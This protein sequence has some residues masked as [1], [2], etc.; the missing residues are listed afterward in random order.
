MENLY[1]QIEN[2]QPINHPVYDFNLVHVFGNIPEGW[3]LF[4]RIE[5]P[6]G[7]LTSPFQKAVNTYG[8]S[9]DNVTWE[10]KWSAVEISDEEK[11]SLIAEKQANPPYPNAVLDTS[12]LTWIR[13]AK[14]T[15]NQNY[16]FNY[17]TGIWTVVPV[18]PDSSKKC[19]FNWDTMEWV[20]ILPTT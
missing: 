4:N 9:S 10:D 16:L 7:L 1:I 20:E 17:K 8:L 19:T 2:G 3:V 18:R 13:P 15:D 5:E 14:P 12:N 6:V 11:A